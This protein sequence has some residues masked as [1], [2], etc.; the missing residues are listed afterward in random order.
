[1]HTYTYTVLQEAEDVPPTDTTPIDFCSWNSYADCKDFAFYDR[2]FLEKSRRGDPVSWSGRERGREKQGKTWEGGGRENR[3]ATRVQVHVHMFH[4][5]VPF[6]YLGYWRV[7]QDTCSLPHCPASEWRWWVH[8]QTYMHIPNN[9]VCL[10]ASFT[11]YN[12]V[13]IYIRVLQANL[14]TMH[15][16]RTRLHLCQLQGILDTY[17]R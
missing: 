16:H 13:Y 17:L 11:S 4:L 10:L 12:Y 6:P 2:D 5:H 7:F 1:M 9:I 3:R 15:S 14:S 8:V